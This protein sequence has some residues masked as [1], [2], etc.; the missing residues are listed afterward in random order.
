[1]LKWKGDGDG[2]KEKKK[3]KVNIDM[4]P[5]YSRVEYDLFFLYKLPSQVLQFSSKL[6]TEKNQKIKTKD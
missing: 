4:A 3:E 6:V 2:K 1:M 5:S